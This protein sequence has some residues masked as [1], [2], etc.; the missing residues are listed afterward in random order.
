MVQDL[1]IYTLLSTL[2]SIESIASIIA[3]ISFIN[4]SII[5]YSHDIKGI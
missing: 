5:G 2:I 4:F 1:L 3:T